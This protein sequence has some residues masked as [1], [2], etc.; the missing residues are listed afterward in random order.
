MLETAKTEIRVVQTRNGLYRFIYSGIDDKLKELHDKGIEIMVLTEVDESGVEAVKNYLTFAHVRHLAVP[1]TMRL[2][3]VDETDALTT[4]AR[5]DSMSLNTE[6]DLAMWV[7]AP[8]YAKSMKL[9]FEALWRESVLARQRL[10]TIAA[11]QTL[12]ESL[13]WAQ[14][15][16]EADGWTTTIPGKLIGESAVEHSFDL[17]ARYPDE[18]NITLVVDSLSEHSSAQILAFN[19]KALDVSP[20]IQLLVTNGPPSDE[21]SELASHRGIKLIHA[22]QSQQLAI[23]IANEANKFLKARTGSSGPDTH[24]AFPGGC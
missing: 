24:H 3:L 18:R 2:I 4:F 9:Y 6:K 8:D 22:A 14:R 16:L 13:G 11:K 7:K 20:T 19:L 17:V 15:T 12:R 21:E 5:D 23:K 10:T 1:S